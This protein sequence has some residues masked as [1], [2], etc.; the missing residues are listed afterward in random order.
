MD[1]HDCNEH[2]FLISGQ[3]FLSMPAKPCLR[4]CG[5]V[6]SE[7]LR[8]EAE[9]YGAAGSKPQVV[10]PNGVLASTAVGLVVQLLTPWYSDPTNFVYL[11]YD[12][13]RGTI[14]PSAYMRLAAGITCSHHPPSEVGDPLFDIRSIFSQRSEQ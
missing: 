10:W 4:C 14:T 13:N 12:G 11:E 1:V 2:G 9:R 3:V 6:T 7:R 5:V 8:R